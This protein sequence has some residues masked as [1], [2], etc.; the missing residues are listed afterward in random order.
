MPRTPTHTHTHG[1]PWPQHQMNYLTNHTAEQ[2]ELC[3]W[4]GHAVFALN[5]SR[6]TWMTCVCV[7]V[8][9]CVEKAE[10]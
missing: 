5:V 10:L 9:E 3:P 7:S 6:Y 8:C 1:L 4:L 2:F